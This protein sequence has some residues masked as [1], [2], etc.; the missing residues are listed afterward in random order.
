[1][2]PPDFR[3]NFFPFAERL[4]NYQ[5]KHKRAHNRKQ[6]IAILDKEIAAILKRASV[7]ATQVRERT[8]TNYALFEKPGHRIG[9]I[10]ITLINR[11]Q[12]FREAIIKMQ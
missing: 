3:K 8:P 1:M 9:N 5:L 6:A 10:T 7:I 4:I 11:L 12:P 2:S